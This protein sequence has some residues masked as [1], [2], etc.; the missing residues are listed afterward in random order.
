MGNY[1]KEI[2]EK[3]GAKSDNVYV[4]MPALYGLVTNIEFPEMSEEDLNQAIE[5]EAYKYV[6]SDLEEVYLSW[7]VINRKAGKNKNELIGDEKDDNKKEKNGSIQVLLVAA[8]Q[9]RSESL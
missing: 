2:M 9:K 6:P 1:V 5:L 3:M 8:P 4:S 7:G